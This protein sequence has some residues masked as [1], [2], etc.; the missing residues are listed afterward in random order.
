M[1]SLHETTR[2]RLCRAAFLALCIVP[3]CAVIA[4]AVYANAPA[5]RRAHERAIAACTGWQAGL[6]GVSSPRP[7]MLLYEGLE[8]SDPDSGELLARLPFVEVTSAGGTVVVKLPF[9]AA[10]NG[11][12]LDAFWKLINHLARRRPASGTLRFCAQNL[13]IRLPEGDHSFTDV[14]GQI[15]GD[16]AHTQAKLTFR[17]AIA[18]TIPA[19]PCRLTLTR[20]GDATTAK[21]VI[22]LTTGSTPLP[23][24][25]FAPL[26]SGAPGFGKTCQFTGHI[27][28]VERSGVW[29]TE[30]E[31]RASGIDLDLVVSRRFP[32]KL[33]GLAEIRLKSVTLEGGRIVRA[34]GSVT[35]GPG[36][37]SR[38]LVQSAQTH[39]HIQAAAQALKG[40]G[41]LIPYQQLSV[42]FKIST[43]GMSLHGEVPGTRGAMLV[44][45]R[46]VL[47]VEPPLVTQP[48]VDLVRTLVPNSEVHVPATRETARLS[49]VLPL[50][51]IVPVP[52][53]EQP[54][55]HA[56]PLSVKPT[57]SA[58]TIRR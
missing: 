48:V 2:I 15:D 44:D 25:L 13:T 16:E 56:R 36:I 19:E 22:Q 53:S 29:T 50:P 51:S 11:T 30:L 28:A 4:W 55:P 8:L 37:I 54:L 7:G 9:P 17:R 5:Y 45:S 31:G 47:A 27:Y 26:W 24:S 1:F 10:V 34:E 52:G 35:A 32:H 41:N 12:R 3:T 49:G 40:R 18:G 58:E 43:E 23:T 20:R 21:Q 14:V 38:S 46:R 6:T 57:R 39:L 33:S 42:G